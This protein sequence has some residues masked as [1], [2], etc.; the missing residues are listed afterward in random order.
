ML[1]YSQTCGVKKYQ[2]RHQAVL[3]NGRDWLPTVAFPFT[4][5]LASGKIARVSAE[6]RLTFI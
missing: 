6:P 4:P 2:S 3:E 1:F 5:Y